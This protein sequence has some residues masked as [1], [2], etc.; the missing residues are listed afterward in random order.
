MMWKNTIRKS[1]IVKARLALND[2]DDGV[3][4]NH[5]KLPSGY[6]LME[7]E[8]YIYVKYD[9]V[10]DTNK[11]GISLIVDNVLIEGYVDFLS[12]DG[13][14]Q[15]E[16][17]IKIEVNFDEISELQLEIESFTVKGSSYSFKLAV[18]SIEISLFYNQSFEVEL[19]KSSVDYI[20]FKQA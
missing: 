17:Q 13:N 2:T 15:K 3:F 16:K 7:E 6:E 9:L 10:L 1:P 4:I 11:D 12:D 20:Y 19:D 8:L 18:D 5:E 14:E